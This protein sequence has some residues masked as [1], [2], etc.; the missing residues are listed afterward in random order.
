MIK[1]KA[2]L[3][4]LDR[5][6]KD[7][8]KWTEE[9]GAVYEEFGADDLEEFACWGYEQALKDIW[10]NVKDEKPELRRTVICVNELV[11]EAALYTN[12]SELDEIE[13]YTKWCYL[14]DILLKEK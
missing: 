14:D 8:R 9:F 7:R 5:K 13:Q 6:V 10:H 12:N 4:A 3:N 11:V 1:N 2:F